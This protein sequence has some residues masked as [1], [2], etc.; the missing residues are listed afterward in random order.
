V[1]RFLPY[2]A[3]AQGD[4]KN[5]EV[6]KLLLPAQHPEKLKAGDFFLLTGALAV[7][8]DRTLEFFFNS[9]E[10]SFPGDA[11]IFYCGPIIRDGRVVSAGPTTSSR[12]DWA[13]DKILSS[14]VNVIIGKGRL[15][16]PGSKILKKRGVY[17]ETPGGAGA[18][19]ASRVI[20]CRTVSYAVLG[21]Q[22]LRLF[23]VKDFPVIVSQDYEGRTIWRQTL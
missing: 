14:G 1:R 12:M 20:S 15:S 11:A 23:E 22:A 16:S 2:R 18:L 10:K 6:K 8:R 4:E 9:R 19:L 7:A 17:F 21:A 3:D 5:S 13:I